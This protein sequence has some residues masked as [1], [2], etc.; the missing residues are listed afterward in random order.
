MDKDMLS[1]LNTEYEKLT[2]ERLNKPIP[3][4]LVGECKE[5]CPRYEKL[6]RMKNNDISEFESKVLIKKYYRSAAGY[7]GCYPEDI[8]TIDTLEKC[9]NYLIS[10]KVDDNNFEFLEN[11]IRAIKGDIAV[12]VIYDVEKVIKILEKIIRWYILS[13]Y[14]LYEKNV[15]DLNIIMNQ[16]RK[17]LLSLISYYKEWDRNGIISINQGEFYGYY[18][19]FNLNEVDFFESLKYD[20][21]Y[22]RQCL[23][24][25]LYYQSNNFHNFFRLK[26][27][28]MTMCVL[29][30]WE[31]NLLN[32]TMKIFHKGFYEKIKK[33]KIDELLGIDSKYL[34]KAYF[35]D[36]DE[37]DFKDKNANGM[38]IIRKYNKKF[39]NDENFYF[40]IIKN[41]N[42]LLKGAYDN[43]KDK[44]IINTALYEDYKNS[45]I[46]NSRN[47]DFDVFFEI[48]NADFKLYE[49]IV[50]RYIAR[51]FEKIRLYKFVICKFCELKWHEKQ[52]T[53]YIRKML[54]IQIYKHIVVNII[55]TCLY[56]TAIKL[57][58]K[59]RLQ[60]NN[61]ILIV[62]SD[63][64]ISNS[65]SCKY[66]SEKYILLLNEIDKKLFYSFKYLTKRIIFS[67]LT[68]E[69]ALKYN[70]IIFYGF[71][72]FINIVK[73]RFY[74]LNLL[75]NPCFTEVTEKSIQ[76]KTFKIR[77]S[78]ALKNKDI[79]EQIK[80]ILH[81]RT[82]L[83]DYK[84]I[85][86]AI[87]EN[88]YYKDRYF[89]Y[90]KYNN[91]LL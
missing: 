51:V 8:R 38:D 74:Y 71:G 49:K 27:D 5:L 19:L 15:I 66:Y 13:L 58:L 63:E 30:F 4:N 72:N 47:K 34:L 22:S 26:F 65:T 36:G 16:G 76:T 41:C 73:E 6:Y 86:L 35:Y 50:K 57:F 1:Y 44:E 29:L 77:I 33:H 39:F 42:N 43:Y 81:F 68:E 14:I 70:L 79:K 59:T 61:K 21:L 32:K 40:Q 83:D 78:D 64:I 17:T 9:L 2:N 18:I 54:K 53:K 75:I 24:I 90:K 60:I 10:I 7:T 11:R 85:I 45:I 31:T 62:T 28:F 12:Q 3:E 87:V 89:Y 69:I 80:T 82:Y 37:I 56:R 67:L 52:K 88:K 23:K 84:E 91:Q 48:G 46:D 55:K 25:A 20:C